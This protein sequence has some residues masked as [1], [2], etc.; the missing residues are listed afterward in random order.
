MKKINSF[1]VAMGV[2]LVVVCLALGLSYDFVSA[3]V[4]M[5]IACAGAALVYVWVDFVTRLIE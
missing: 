5:A 4:C 2:P 1:L 3:T